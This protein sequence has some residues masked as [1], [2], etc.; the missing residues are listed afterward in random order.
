MSVPNDLLRI[1]DEVD[2]LVAEIHETSACGPH[3]RIVHRF[4][5]AGTVCTPG[6]EIV[7]AYFVHH[8]REYH[9][10]LSL[11]LR[12]L[13]DY[14]ARHSRLPQSAAQIEAGIRA[15]NF[16]AQHGAAVLGHRRYSCNIPRSYVRVYAERLRE[17]IEKVF[18]EAGLSMDPHTVLLSEETVMNE[19][20]YRIKASFE[21]MHIDA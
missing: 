20:G 13:F 18:R 19:V 15:D 21:W 17:A 11:G 12:I 10:R 6:E 8:G 2:L 5:K 16:Y 1:I 9:L 4:R 7:A 3:F 14:L